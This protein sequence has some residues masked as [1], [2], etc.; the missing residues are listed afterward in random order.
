MF[1]NFDDIAKY[2]STEEKPETRGNV[3]DLELCKNGYDTLNLMANHS[4]SFSK[5]ILLVVKTFEKITNIA[6]TGVTYND[7]EKL[8]P[9]VLDSTS[10]ILAKK[11]KIND[12]LDVLIK[13]KSLRKFIKIQNLK[14]KL[15]KG[16]E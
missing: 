6:G 16:N 13:L 8:T 11:H 9:E 3:I 12:M 2:Y 15:N 7:I 4:S 14:S 5:N 10:I 1:K